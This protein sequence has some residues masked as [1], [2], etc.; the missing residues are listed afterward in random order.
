L[1]QTEKKKKKKE[2]Q[3]GSGRAEPDPGRIQPS[4]PAS[5]PERGAKLVRGL[6]HWIRRRS[7]AIRRRRHPLQQAREEVGAS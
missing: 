1:N 2:G 4:W 5:Q 3:A 6:G 7:T